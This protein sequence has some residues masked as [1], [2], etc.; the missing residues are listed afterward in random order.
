MKKKS[1]RKKAVTPERLMQMAW[2]YAAPLMIETAVRHGIFDLL[3]QGARTVKQIA[4]ET[5]ASVRG[6]TALLNGL[7]SLNLLSRAGDR[8]ALAPESAEFM[9]SSKPSYHG[10]FFRHISDQLIPSW[11][12]LP[13]VVR[14]GEPAR[15]IETPGE[16]GDFFAKFVES[17]FPLS[18]P[19]ASQLGQ[20]LD[21][22]STTEPLS[23]LDIGAGSG[24]WGIALAKQSPQV[25]IH[26]VDWPKVLEVTRKVAARH[27]LAERLTTGAGDFFEADFGGNHHVAAIGHIL[28]SEGAE[29]SRRLIKK[30]FDSLA[31][32]GVIAIQEFLPNDERTGPPTALIFALNM[33]VNTVEGDTFTFPEISSWLT[34]AGFINPRLL[35]VPAVSPLILAEKPGGRTARQKQSRKQSRKI[36]TPKKANSRCSR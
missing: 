16:S 7:V 26:A 11:L 6:L 34:E 24:V 22:A 35:D 20:H 18:F 19:A 4:Q 23:I 1:A 28:H 32:G 31:P 10:I 8:Y 9:V 36:R 3:D 30:V 33:L 27:G 5:G 17:I 14:T 25:R 21:V 13:E 12:Q 15:K 2:G 29:R